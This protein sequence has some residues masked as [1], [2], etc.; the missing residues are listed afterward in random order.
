MTFPDTKASLRTDES[1]RLM[2]DA[3]HHMALSP[4]SELNIG[5]VSQFPL[6]YMHMV[7]LGVVRR[8]LNL[9][10]RG[11]R[12]VRLSSNQ[13]KVISDEMTSFQAH[14]PVEFSRK[15]RSLVEI[16]NWKATEFREFLL[17]T[18][19]VVMKG[20]VSEDIY[21]N[22]LRLSV[23]MRLLLSPK[24]AADYSDYC[25]KLLLCF[26]KSFSQLHGTEEVVYNVHSLLHIHQD[27]QRFGALDNISAFPFESYLGRLKKLVRKPQYP[28]Q[29]VCR[30]LTEINK[31][32]C[33]HRDQ[34]KK[35]QCLKAHMRG[36]L[37]LEY[38]NCLQL[39]EYRGNSYLCCTT[40]NDC[41]IIHNHI[42]LVRNILLHTATQ[43]VFIAFERFEKHEPFFLS[44]LSSDRLSIFFVQQ[45][46][47][48]VEVFPVSEVTTKCVLLPYRNNFVCFP[49]LHYK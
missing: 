14:F 34:E 32:H 27:A 18:G 31:R 29:Q 6:D 15:P 19:P 17:Y 41:C 28:L 38:R 3:D 46:S 48:T 16:N 24:L 1:F 40:G 47:G 13:A 49:L 45:L 5:L 23:A 4:L 36:P 9:W 10:L 33:C 7:C 12:H 20:K 8:L 35:A 2:L 43:Q 37:P 11:P 22:F 25:G 42:G 30:R 21:A 44:P 26:V 39:R